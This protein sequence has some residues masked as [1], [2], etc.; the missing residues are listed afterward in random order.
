MFALDIETESLIP[1]MKSFAALEPW[2]LR[3]KK[4]RI[5]SIALSDGRQIENNGPEWKTQVRELLQSLK[6]EVVYAHNALFDIAW[7]IEELKDSKTSPIPKEITD[8]QWRDTGLLAKWLINGQ[9][10]EAI[11]VSYSLKNLVASFLKDHPKTEFFVKLKSQNV[12]PGDN[13][14][15]WAQRGQMDAIMTLALAEKFQ[16]LLPARQRKGFLIEQKCLVP[17]ANSWVVGIRIDLMQLTENE[18]YYTS[19]IA[20]CAKKLGVPRDYFT[21]SRK[22]G[23]LMYETWGI[24]V[25]SKTP[26]G[27]PSASAETIK[28]L[29]YDAKNSGA[30]VVAEKLQIILD[31]KKASTMMSKYVKSMKD[32]LAHTGDGYIYSSP[33]IFATNTGRMTYS[34]STNVYL[35]GK[36]T[37]TAFKTSIALHQIPRNEVRV[38]RCL[39]PPPGMLIFESDAAQQE[40][41]IMAIES[42]DENMINAFKAGKNLHSLLAANMLGLDYEDFTEKYKAEGGH[43][44]FTEQRQFAKLTNLSCNFRI[45]GKSL[46]YKAYT[47]Y[48]TYMTEGQGQY[49]V[50][51]FMKSYPGIPNFWDSVVLDSKERGYT[52][53][54]SKR[55]YKLNEWSGRNVWGTESKAINHPIQGSGADMKEVVISEMFEKHPEAIFILDLHDAGFWLINEESQVKELDKSLNEIDYS[56]HWDMELPISLPMESGFGRS[57]ADIK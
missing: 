40:S 51:Q 55:S 11:N 38:R 14:E 52:E 1:E 45:G 42:K 16:T 53:S 4:A 37:K 2:R 8:I 32:A 19:Q 33:K 31:A 54:F 49:L 21:S 57:W 22:L 41:R 24:P 6:G 20:E 18:K 46:A 30:N 12:Q 50:K 23:N 36:K 28:W 47:T 34:N 29:I 10:A 17:I 39:L 13:P 48:D 7:L 15:Y 44:Y 9:K 26:A 3:Q 35:P 5:T 56:V 27:T 43:G 25:K